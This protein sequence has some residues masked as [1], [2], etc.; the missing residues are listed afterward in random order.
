LIRRAAALL[1]LVPAA[2]AAQTAT[3]STAIAVQQ[4]RPGA[5]RSDI[6]GVSSGAVAGHL[7]WHAG[8]WINYGHAPLRIVNQRTGEPAYN[9]INGLAATDLVGSVGINDL[10]ELGLHIPLTAFQWGDPAPSLGVGIDSGVSP[11]AVGDFRVLFKM[12]LADFYGLRLAWA[13][14]VV[15]PSGPNNS[16]F[17]QASFGI[18]PTALADYT[19]PWGGVRIAANVGVRLRESRKLLNLDV[20][21]EFFYGVAAEYP[22]SFAG[23]DMAVQAAWTGALGL[24]HVDPEERPMELLAG[25]SYRLWK[26]LTIR[27]AGGP[28]LSQGYGTPQFRIVAAVTYVPD[29]PLFK[30][31]CPDNAPEDLDGFEDDDHCADPDNDGDGI[32][33]V[34][35]GAPNAPEDYDGFQDEDGVPDPDNDQ[36][37]IEDHN[38]A[39]PDVAGP[40]EHKGCPADRDGDGLDDADDRCPDKKGPAA[41][42]GCPDADVDGD[43]VVDTLDK[44]PDKQ[45]LQENAG[46]PDE[47]RDGDG[48]IDRLDGCPDKGGPGENKGCPDA[49]ADGDGV[50]DRSDDCPKLAGRAEYHGCPVGDKDG[51]GLVDQFDACPSVPG[52]VENRGCPPQDRDGD[53][54]MDRLDRCPDDKGPAENDGCADN[55][56]D[57]DGIKDRFDRCPTLPE[58]ADNFRDT[59][60]CPDLDN[61]ED[62]MVDAADRCPLEKGPPENHGCP[63][64]DRDGDTVV[65]RLDNC[66]DEPGTPDNQGCRGKQLVIIR[67]E[68]LEILETVY[69]TPGK[70]SIEARSFP[71]LDNVRA[72]MDAHKEIARVIIEGHT[73]SKGSAVKNKALSQKRAEAVREYLIVRGID[74]GRLEAV[75]YGPE[76]PV[77]DNETEAGRAANRRV[78]FTIE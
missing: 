43:G 26:G 13:A 52:E 77:A 38:D 36:D 5:G 58:D 20:G 19:L 64:D 40:P 4:F 7:E 74:P 21:S 48:V 34:K 47:D 41:A 33:D 61:D 78:E 16:F 18:E 35:D 44:C 32:L 46:C 25:F 45:G 15:L 70:A 31:P 76:R 54:V 57:A 1:I 2:A 11:I 39:C 17:G 56:T 14:P 62:G 53:G 12:H 67:K 65:D 37:G 6:L 51:D 50:N 8:L 30:P 60:G 72:V 9:L 42:H 73:D 59:D 27:L 75:G 24:G 22:F 68:K 49:D 66:P 69:F 10:F 29:E 55:D 63:D 23:Y 28:G 71:L 3:D